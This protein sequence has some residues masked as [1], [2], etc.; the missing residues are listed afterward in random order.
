ML[1]N[2]L[3]SDLGIDCRSLLWQV[4][5]DIL[6]SE[7]AAKKAA[8]AAAAAAGESD[9]KKLKASSSSK[10]EEN[11]DGGSEES[12][13]GEPAPAAAESKSAA[14]PMD[15]EAGD[16]EE[17]C[18]AIGWSNTS[19]EPSSVQPLCSQ[20]CSRC[21]KHSPCFPVQTSLTHLTSNSINVTE[22]R[23]SCARHFWP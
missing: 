9:P 5:A 16:D 17:V 22:H 7:T 11:G 1:V 13:G 3:I 14:E 2:D 23:R 19:F 21:C 20:R 12:K 10:A 6:A 15:V 8:E 4:D 18:A